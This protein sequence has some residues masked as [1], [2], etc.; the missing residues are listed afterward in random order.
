MK[1]NTWFYA[2]GLF[3]IALGKHAPGQREGNNP[4]PK[5]SA[6]ASLQA[7]ASLQFFDA[8]D[9]QDQ[10]KVHRLERSRSQADVTNNT[11]QPL[12]LRNCPRHSRAF[13]W[14]PNLAAPGGGNGG[15]ARRRRWSYGGGGRRPTTGVV[16]GGAVVVA[17]AAVGVAAAAVAFFSVPPEKTAKIDMAVVCLDHGLRDPSSST[18]YKMVPA[19]AVVDRPAVVELLKAFGRGELKHGA[20]QAAAWHLNNDLS[21]QQLAAKLQGTKRSFKRPPYFSAD[22]IRTAL[23]QPAESAKRM[24]SSTHREEE[25]AESRRRAATSAAPPTRTAKSRRKEATERK[26]TRP[27]QGCERN[28][29]QNEVRSR[30]STSSRPHIFHFQIAHRGQQPANFRLVIGPL[31]VPLR[32]HL[33]VGL[34]LAVEFL[35][36]RYQPRCLRFNID[37]PPLRPRVKL[38]PL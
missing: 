2:L 8:V 15:G 20:A 34:L 38:A 32:F 14:Q 7:S 29:R 18:A 12:N 26:P 28:W 16:G 5:I 22:E 27:T 23:T 24:P 3:A 31:D 21:W 25:R 9:G 17:V 36:A 11:K 30:H 10:C 35:L 13:P 4:L 6:A 37:V 33:L 19:D 1:R